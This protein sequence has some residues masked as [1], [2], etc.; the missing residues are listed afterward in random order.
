MVSAVMR[1]EAMP[2]R[3]AAAAAAAD[4]DAS[5]WAE[6]VSVDAMLTSLLGPAE[7]AVRPKAGAGHEAPHFW[8]PVQAVVTPPLPGVTP[9][10]S[11]EPRFLGSAQCLESIPAQ[12]GHALRAEV[13]ELEAALAAA[14]LEAEGLA[15]ER[16]GLQARAE[17]LWAQH[18]ALEAQSEWWQ[19]REVLHREQASEALAVV[20]DIRAAAEARGVLCAQEV[21]CARAAGVRAL[22]GEVNELRSEV[23]SLRDME[24]TMQGMLSEAEEAAARNAADLA[25]ER[26]DR[27]SANQR[28]ARLAI[29]VAARRLRGS[30]A[31]KAGLMLGEEDLDDDAVGQIDPHSCVDLLEACYAAPDHAEAHKLMPASPR[32][33]MPARQL[34]KA[35]SAGRAA[36]D[37]L[38]AE[39]DLRRQ[40][41]ASGPLSPPKVPLP[42]GFC[43]EAQ[44]DGSSTSH[45]RPTSG[46]LSWSG[47]ASPT[48]GPAGFSGSP[49]GLGP[50]VREVPSLPADVGLLEDAHHGPERPEQV[51]PQPSQS[52]GIPTANGVPSGS[53]S[54]NLEAL[55]ASLGLNVRGTGSEAASRFRAPSD[56]W[57]I[58]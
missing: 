3:A 20:N 1:P 8:Q 15:E 2:S 46:P 37:L 19:R 30:A 50:T 47:S 34:Q 13:A 56:S 4:R 28:L 18:S 48:F 7:Y 51:R 41:E 39:L 29:T 23:H 53:P 6:V 16:S 52:S 11:E 42:G 24:L 10:A 49:Q 40:L 44:H 14:R 54:K 35:A 17:S 31:G 33:T 32:G 38:T 45:V 43:L 21:E 26:L 25:L 5:I 12:E 58:P 22:E 55:A 57:R 27:A 36:N 9:S